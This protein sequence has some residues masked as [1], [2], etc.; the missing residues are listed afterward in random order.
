MFERIKRRL[1]I[2]YG[3]KEK[4]FISGKP[5]K[6]SVIKDWHN[7]N[8]GI[9]QTSYLS[10]QN[11]WKNND[12]ILLLEEQN[13]MLLLTRVIN[14]VFADESNSSPE[15]EFASR[16]GYHLIAKFKK[17]HKKV[18]YCD[19]QAISIF[20]CYTMLRLTKNKLRIRV[21]FAEKELSISHYKEIFENGE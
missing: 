3:Y 15:F 8:Y 19:V 5:V 13:Y 21:I 7:P 1:Y 12:N 4:D 16:Y 17:Y 18:K 11:R 14:M 10:F 2:D 9:N 6:I 20:L